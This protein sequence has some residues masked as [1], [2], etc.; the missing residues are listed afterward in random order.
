MPLHY[1]SAVKKWAKC[2]GIYSNVLGFLGGI[3]WAILVAFLCQRYPR[4][5]P[6][7]LLHRFGPDH[8]KNVSYMAILSKPPLSALLLFPLL[9][10]YHRF[11]WW[12]AV[13]LCGVLILPRTP[14]DSSVYTIDGS[15]RILFS[16]RI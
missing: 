6:A 1:L 4:A 15:G 3:N 12:S 2:C 16:S 14:K 8:K 10:I 5:P 7:A 9:H 11:T 13:C